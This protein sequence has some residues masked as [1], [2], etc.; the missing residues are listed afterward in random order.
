MPA[1]RRVVTGRRVLVTLVAATG[2]ALTPLTALAAPETP[3]TS[4]EVAALVA[5]RGHDLEVVTEQFNDARVLLEA[6]QTAA[7]EAARGVEA[8][9]AAVAESRDKVRQVARSAY[10]GD[11]LSTLQAML[12]SDSAGE[13]LDQ[14]GTLDTIAQYNNGILGAAQEATEAAAATKAAAD[15]TAAEAKA[16]LDR[17]TAQQDELKSEI[18]EYQAAYDKLNADEQARARQLA[19]Q[20]HAAPAVD[21]AVR[22]NPSAS[23]SSAR[24]PAPPRSPSRASR[25]CGPRPARARSTAPVSSSSP[26]RRP[27]CPC[28][29]PAAARPAWAEPSRGPSCSRAT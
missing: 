22:D 10:T 11:Q 4:Q 29:T 21:P 15:R 13:L 23:R 16:Q 19:E 28:R 20:A 1:R 8:A 26:T 2:V 7:D 17:V 25:T 18:A 14:I 5:A 27:G 24:V 12:T 3:R 6:Q 9:E